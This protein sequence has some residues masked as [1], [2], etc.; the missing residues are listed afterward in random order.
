[1]GEMGAEAIKAGQVSISR[2]AEQFDL[3]PQE[4]EHRPGLLTLLHRLNRNYIQA[5]VKS[6]EEALAKSGN[7]EPK[8]GEAEQSSEPPSLAGEAEKLSNTSLAKLSAG[9]SESSLD[10]NSSNC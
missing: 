6:G 1:M 8:P 9:S 3:V 2:V 7:D 10:P 5:L 4:G